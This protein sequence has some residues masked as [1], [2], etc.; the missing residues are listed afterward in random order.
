MANI[1]QSLHVI[2]DLERI[3]V[4]NPGRVQ[5]LPPPFPLLNILWKWNNIQDKW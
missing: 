2:G 3:T 5:G 1:A 4:V